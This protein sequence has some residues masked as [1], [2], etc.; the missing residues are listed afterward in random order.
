MKQI[1]KWCWLFL[2]VM[3]MA[4]GCK[5]SRSGSSS[6]VRSSGDKRVTRSS[7]YRTKEK[8]AE[9]KSSA[10]SRWFSRSEDEAPSPARKSTSRE[11][12]VAVP[13]LQA[14]APSVAPRQRTVAAYRLKAGDPVMIFLRGIPREEEIEDIVD[15]DG[16][17]TMP[18]INTIRA[19]GLTSAELEREIRRTYLDEK[20]YRNITVNVVMSSQSYFVRGE[21]RQP[22][23]Y[24]MI[25]GVTISQAIAT[26]GGYTDYA[27][28]RKI[29]ITRGN[30][31]F[32]VD[33]NDLR[34][35]PDKDQNL[36]AGDVIVVERK[37]F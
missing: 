21:V 37:F 11:S 16:Y 6:Y 19:A 13:S 1:S 2:V 18:Y 22:G 7:T 27:N 29:S 3:I 25:T 35:H 17:I 14:S 4:A 30:K 10:F 34:E 26:A 9:K 20:I 36:E 12:T 28:S 5:S 8:P 23:R 31:T 33:A 15:E 32:Y 24:P